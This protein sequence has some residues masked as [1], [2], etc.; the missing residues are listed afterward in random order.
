MLLDSMSTGDVHSGSCKCGAITFIATGIPK[1]FGWCHCWRCRADTS[2]S[3]VYE[4]TFD[5]AQFSHNIDI[6]HVDSNKIYTDQFGTNNSCIYYRCRQCDTRVFDN[7]RVNNTYS[8]Y[9]SLF[10]FA[11]HTTNDA[12]VKQLP[13][14]WKHTAH[15][16]YSMRLHGIEV[17]DGLP[18]YSTSM[19]SNI[20]SVTKSSVPSP[21]IN[22]DT[23]STAQCKC[24][25]IQW[26]VR[27]NPIMSQYCHCYRCRVA[28]SAEY[29]VACVIKSDQFTSNIDTVDTSTYISPL[30][31]E[32]Y[33]HLTYWKCIKCDT[34]CYHR[35]SK[36]NTVVVYPSLF[37]WAIG[38]HNN[39]TGVLPLKWRANA[40]IFYGSR[41]GG[42][43]VDDGLIYYTGLCG[44]E[45]CDYQ[46]NIIKST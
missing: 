37:T 6:N 43:D 22:D 28:D 24:G 29:R 34:R 7:N 12:Q 42:H 36:L 16:Y 39:T 10:N 21:T 20:V 33:E 25:N 9:P 23:I 1:F 11:R 18:H 17:D 44:K 3:G 35:N 46:G 40:H 13:S 32:G 4:V 2:S 26:S 15:I 5:T 30:F 8:T 41:L 19:S 14:T 38:E 45:Q 31:G 27:G